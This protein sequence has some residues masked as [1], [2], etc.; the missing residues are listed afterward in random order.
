MHLES[1][2]LYALYDNDNNKVMS[3]GDWV[4]SASTNLNVN[5][6]LHNS[7]ST[8]INYIVLWSKKRIIKDWIQHKSL[9]L[10]IK[11]SKQ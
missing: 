9:L 5:L 6:E 3:S 8:R 11:Q 1:Y 2:C 7:A 4:S 10:I